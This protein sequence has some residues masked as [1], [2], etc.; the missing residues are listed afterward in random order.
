MFKSAR[1]AVLFTLFT[2]LL[3]NLCWAAPGPMEK[4]KVT[5]GEVIEIIKTSDLDHEQKRAK[6][7]TTIRNSFDFASM[8]QRILARNWQQTTS[9]E[10]E[11]FIRLLSELL[12]RNYIGNIENYTDEKVE[13]TKE[14]I[15]KNYA[16][17]DTL[18]ITKSKEIPVSY[19]MQQ[20]GEEWRVYDVV[21]ESVSFVNNYRNSY[22]KIIKKQGIAGLL[23][24]MEEK[25]VQLR[26]EG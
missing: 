10:R 3:T 20:K 15:K 19:R 23:A 11:Q 9:Q 2:L 1:Y 13:F 8:S 14:R 7:S 22:G 24:K 26:Q 17:I 21:I 25:L 12:E 6:L 16:A 18:I 5:V 4:V